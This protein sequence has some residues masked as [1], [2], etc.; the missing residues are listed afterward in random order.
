MLKRCELTALLINKGGF[1]PLGE[2]QVKLGYKKAIIKDFL[3]RLKP[4][5]PK[6]LNKR[7]CLLLF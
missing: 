5:K 7:V 1:P 6:N 2:N 3:V 4:Q